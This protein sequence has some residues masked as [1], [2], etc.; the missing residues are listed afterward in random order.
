MRKKQ[1]VKQHTLTEL[2]P[3]IAPATWRA[4]K[5]SLQCHKIVALAI[6]TTFT[7]KKLLHSAAGKVTSPPLTTC[8]LQNCCQLALPNWSFLAVFWVSH[9]QGSELL[10]DL[11]HWLKS[12]DTCH[13]CLSKMLLRELMP[14]VMRSS[15]ISQEDHPPNTLFSKSWCKALSCEWSN[16]LDTFTFWDKWSSCLSLHVSWR[17]DGPLAACSQAS[18]QKTCPLLDGF[19]WWHCLPARLPQHS[20]H[21]QCLVLFKHQLEMEVWQEQFCPLLPLPV[22]SQLWCPTKHAPSTH[23]LQWLQNQGDVAPIFDHQW[24]IWVLTLLFGWLAKRG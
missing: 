1:I 23:S 13:Q 2:S 12:K 7:T 8:K 11:N 16:L 22:E 19:S 5:K 14:T 24:Q 4:W 18:Q 6:S 20:F 15:A 21:L 17:L 10:K 9:G 3:E